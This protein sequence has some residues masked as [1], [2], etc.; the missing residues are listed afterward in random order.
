MA[1]YRAV[2]LT[3]KGG[4]EVLEDVDLPLRDP[5]PGE[6]RV[7]VRA[8]GVGATD[9]LMR[10][11]YY[12][13]APKI[14][15]VQGY[16]VVGEVDAIGSGVTEV[17]VGDRVASLA[18]W[19]GHAEVFYRGADELVRVPA[20]LDDAEVV[21]LILNYATAYQM[22]YR[23]AQQKRGE[24]AL[25]T[26]ANGGVGQALLELL[27]IE[28][29]TAYGAAG[30]RSHEL[31]RSLGG[32]PIEGRDTPVD[33][34]L[35][36]VLPAGVDAAYDALGG[37]FVAQCTRATRRGGHVIGYG[38]SGAVG[39]DGAPSTGAA[40]R[41]LLRLHVGSK[42]AGRKT[43]MYGITARYR[44]D[45]RPFLEDLSKLFE[46]LAGKKLHPKIS[47]RMP[48]LAVRAANER[49]EAGGV[50]G[51]IVLLRDVA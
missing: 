24:T 43:T 41:G 29:V 2:M 33:D 36:A 31:V 16:D 51:K 8:C 4:P 10:R 3:R 27:A 23:V 48:L 22:V 18:V 46:L 21:A 42:L 49:L 47:A 13:F 44:K 7:R 12:P 50:D 11:G 30:K 19:G 14:P 26:G 20:G 25:I 32:V 38:F 40:M 35:R 15:F 34:S 6:A 39:K 1:T 45:K 9:L 5:A 28:G 17:A 37:R